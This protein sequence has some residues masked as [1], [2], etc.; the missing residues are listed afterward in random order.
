MIEYIVRRRYPAA[1]QGRS[2]IKERLIDEKYTGQADADWER[3]TE[4]EIGRVAQDDWC[5]ASGLTQVQ[6]AALRE[7]LSLK[8]ELQEMGRDELRF[9][10]EEECEKRPQL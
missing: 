5:E 1:A 3:I 2:V 6:H 4:Q 9:T 10:Y 7:A 8:R